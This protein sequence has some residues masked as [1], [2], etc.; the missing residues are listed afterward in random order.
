MSGQ[1]DILDGLEERLQS[2]AK[3]FESLLALTPA[4]E[5]Y[6]SQIVDGRDPND[7]WKAKKQTKEEKQAAKKAKLDPANQKSALDIMKERE[8]KRKREL[9]M[10]EEEEQTVAAEKPDGGKRQKV[11]ET[12]EEA[13]ARRRLKATQRKEKREKKKEKAAKLKEKREA[14]KA[15]K[16]DGE[17]NNAAK[18][19]SKPEKASTNGP[20]KDDD[21][22]EDDDEEDDE[23]AEMVDGSDMDKLDMS[24]L[25]DSDAASVA[26]TAPSSP[27]IDSPA[28]DLSTNHSTAS[29]SSSIIPPSD[30][31][32]SAPS[33]KAQQSVKQ[34]P[35]PP[36]L[37]ATKPAS[38]TSSPRL[39]LPNIDS[40]AL[41]DRLRSRIEELRN[42]RKADG[43]E[44][45]NPKSRQEL[46]DQ[47]RKKEEQRK[48]HKK[49]LRRQAKEEEDK[50]QEE[51]LRGSGSPLSVDI[52]SPRETAPKQDSNNFSFSRLAFDDGTAPD[53]SL[54]QLVDP[55]KRKGPQ[56][57]KTALALAEAK[58][59]RLAGYDAEKRADIAEKDL[60][61]NAKKRAHG[62]RVR[63]D[64]SL[65]KKALKR[66]EKAKGKSEKEWK[67]REDAVV[68][69]KQMKDKKRE[70][71][72][73]ARAD[74]KGK[75][76]KQAKSG[77]KPGG[78]KGGRPGFE[79]RFKA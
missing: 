25:V 27:A 70:A 69:G 23:Q 14:K 45:K 67:D 15:A 71:N 56:D 24:G 22:D 51:R 77:G 28:F 13:E 64:T 17:V 79:G 78:K 54:S 8:L 59:K 75:K 33:K 55:K 61:L 65:L 50:K 63:D 37:D 53:A 49:E 39:N 26:S 9:G 66:K 30:Q 5:Y 74:G 3:A 18:G 52:F 62:E 4:Q 2:H 38:G 34:Q 40:E 29:S 19:Q 42:K 20:K 72:L 16:Q 7:Q 1:E 60:W 12:P 21:E 48:A 41:Q 57:T 43:P 76:G 46:L 44:G 58:Q 68:K 35:L 31:P 47:R 10:D 73:K 36:A 32:K 11:E 6:G